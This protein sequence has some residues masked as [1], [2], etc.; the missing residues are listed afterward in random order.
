MNQQDYVSYE[1]ALKLKEC[2]FDEPCAHYYTKENAADGEVWFTSCSFS[3]EDWNNGRNKEPDFLKPLC[4]APTLWEAQKWLRDEKEIDID[5]RTSRIGGRK[6]DFVVMN[7]IK[8]FFSDEYFPYYESAL[9]SG[10]S[11]ALEIL[12]KRV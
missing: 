10:I 6:Y 2:S 7:G 11:A 12:G 1:L 9:S 4:S 8:Q 3:P 5:I